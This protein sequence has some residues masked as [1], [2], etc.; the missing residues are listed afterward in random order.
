MSASFSNSESGLN[1]TLLRPTRI[2]RLSMEPRNSCR[3]ANPRPGSIASTPAPNWWTAALIAGWRCTLLAPRTNPIFFA[4]RHVSPLT[5]PTA[6]PSWSIAAPM[7]G[8]RCMRSIS[9]DSSM[10][11]HCSGTTA[12][13][14]DVEVLRTP[15]E[16][17]KVGIFGCHVTSLQACSDYLKNPDVGAQVTTLAYSHTDAVSAASSNPNSPHPAFLF[18]PLLSISSF[19]HSPIP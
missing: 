11:R 9:N 19:S 17:E 16:W 1:G 5:S 14:S 13:W 10:R 18:P 3:P 4:V 8:W 6:A 7:A 15:N 2:Y 12:R